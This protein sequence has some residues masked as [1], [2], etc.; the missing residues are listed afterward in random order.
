MSRSRRVESVDAPFWVSYADL[1]TA[2]VMLLLLVMAISMLAVASRPLLERK[3][4]DAAVDIFFEQ[5]QQ[6]I[7]RSA[8][9]MTANRTA[10]TIGLGDRVRFA[11][12]SYLLSAEAKRQMQAVV[13][14][15]LALHAAE[16]GRSWLKRVHIEGYTDETGTYLYNVHL[17]L[18][19][20]QS[21]VCALFEADITA[22]EQ[23]RLQQLLMIDGATTT[24]IKSTREESRRV[25]IRLEFRSVD[26]EEPTLPAPEVALGRCPIQTE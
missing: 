6:Q 25:E 19:R 3:Q 10:H 24:S 21:V 5:L 16:P 13:P 22:A 7:Q 17:S 14:L 12:D 9:D 15:L 4:R 11:H 8:L 20:A 18:R 23:R 2:L 1:M 26:D